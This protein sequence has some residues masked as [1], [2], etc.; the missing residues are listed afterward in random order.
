[1]ITLH[2]A[3]RALNPQVVTIRGEDAFDANDKPV[4]YDLSAAQAKLTQMQADEATAQQTAATNKASA[5]AK[6]TALGLTT[7]EISALGVA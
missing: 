3:I 1:M 7:D 4:N 5:I 6:L 2:D